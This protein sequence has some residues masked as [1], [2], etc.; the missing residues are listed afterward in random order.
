M[1]I[2]DPRSPFLADPP[3]LDTDGKPSRSIF[4]LVKIGPA[5]GPAEDMRSGMGPGGRCGS[6]LRNALAGVPGIPVADVYKS[7]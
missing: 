4:F 2:L 6:A 1:E 3:V 5:H 7:S